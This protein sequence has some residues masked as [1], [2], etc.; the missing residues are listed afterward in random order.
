MADYYSILDKTISRLP[1]NTAANRSLVFAKAREAIE[2]QLRGLTPSPS[3]EAIARQM[4]ALE[5]AISRIEVEQSF[6]AD[7]DSVA[8]AVTASVT[9]LDVAAAPASESRPAPAAPAERSEPQPVTLQT[10]PRVAEQDF[11]ADEPDK[12]GMVGRVLP[13]LLGLVVVGGGAYGLWL[14]KDALL[15]AAKPTTEVAAPASGNTPAETQTPG[16]AETAE[17]GSSEKESARLGGNGEDVA[18][19]PIVV[20]PVSQPNGSD[21]AEPLLLQPGSDPSVEPA[22]LTEKPVEVTEVGKAADGTPAATGLPAIAQKAYLYEEGGA[23]GAASRSDAAIVW[24]LNQEAP[25][26]DQPAEAVVK[27]RLDIPGN[28][29]SMVIT[30]KRNTDEG[31]PASHIIELNFEGGEIDN[32]ARFVMKATEQARGEGLVA[33]P[34]KIDTGYFLIALN[35]LPQAVETNSKLLLESD[36]I[37]IPLGYATGRR[38]LVTL[39]KGVI[40]E[41]VFRE[42]FEDWKNR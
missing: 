38:A 30:I 31:L 17:I 27:G 33:V 19:E 7:M 32:V 22:P 2:R 28:P 25:S 8:E 41:K 34:A 23:N 35:N 5:N 9:G 36:W 10:S 11:V 12:R 18:P 13:Y 24:T 4:S 26:P 16:K 20:E 21:T 3:E 29:L 14:N 42:A 15:D 6:D 40:G 1:E 37:D 39:E